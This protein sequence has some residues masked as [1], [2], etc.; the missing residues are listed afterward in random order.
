MTRMKICIIH[1]RLTLYYLCKAT[2]Y[3]IL[4]QYFLIFYKSHGSNVFN[5]PILLVLAGP[6]KETTTVYATKLISPETG[7]LNIFSNNQKSDTWLYSIVTWK[8]YSDDKGQN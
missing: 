2:V 4:M 3:M 5:F 6:G 8:Y 1:S 7:F